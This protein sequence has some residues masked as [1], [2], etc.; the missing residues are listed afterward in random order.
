MGTKSLDVCQCGD[1]RSKEFQSV[2]REFLGSDV[3]LERLGIDP[4][5]LASISIC[6]KRVIRARG[7]VSATVGC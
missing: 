6:W 2:C 1:D 4:A 3:F 7:V 5:E